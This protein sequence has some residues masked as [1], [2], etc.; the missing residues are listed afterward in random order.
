MKKKT[1]KSAVIQEVSNTLTPAYKPS[2]NMKRRKNKKNRTI[3]KYIFKY[4]FK[5]IEAV[6][7]ILQVF[8]LIKEFFKKWRRV[9]NE[10]PIKFLGLL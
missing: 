9:W 3:K 1:K 10:K 6:G 5:C 7:F 2:S 8:Q 4:L